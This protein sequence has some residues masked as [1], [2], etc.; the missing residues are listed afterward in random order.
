MNHKLVVIIQRTGCGRAGAARAFGC[1]CTG[2]TTKEHATTNTCT[3]VPVPLA[4]RMD[5]DPAVAKKVS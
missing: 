2:C 3:R 1:K 5:E 4:E